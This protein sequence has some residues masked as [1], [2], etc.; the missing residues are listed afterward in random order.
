[1]KF[2]ISDLD[3]DQLCWM[4]ESLVYRI[5]SHNLLIESTSEIHYYLTT[6]EIRTHLL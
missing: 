4:T 2:S 6:T 5:S 3:E 1:M